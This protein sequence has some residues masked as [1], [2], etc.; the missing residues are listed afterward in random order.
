M[1]HIVKGPAPTELEEFKDNFRIINHREPMYKDFRETDAWRHLREILLGEQ[2]YICCYCMQGI[3]DWDSHLEHF[4]P[5][6]DGKLHPHSILSDHIE[7]EYSNLFMSCN[8]E[9]SSPREHCGHKKDDTQTAM[10]VCPTDDD[11]E[12]QFSYTINGKIDGITPKA[13]TT[14]RVLGLDS[15]ALERHRKTAIYEV[16]KE[17]NDSDIDMLIHKYEC[18]DARG[19][20]TP[21]CKA[22]T[23]CLRHI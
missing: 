23:Y 11:V 6:V 22:I 18:R 10:L 13:M 12:G 20:F 14:I 3:E 7:L 2:G 5:R 1:K 8:G 19:M 21:Y 9:T 4:T 17:L 16:I 15:Y